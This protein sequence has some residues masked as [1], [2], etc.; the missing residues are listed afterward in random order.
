MRIVIDMQ[1][2]QASNKQ[3]GIGRYSLAFAK[4][5][6]RN[7]GSHEVFILLNGCFAD[8]V[9][10]LREEFEKLL[11]KECIHVWY[12]TGPLNWSG[13]MNSWRRSVAEMTREAAIAS[14]NPSVIVVTSIFE[15]L[16]DD[17]V[18]SVG[19][20]PG[21]PPTVAV[22][23]DLIPALNPDT[24]LANPVVATWY[25]D[26]LRH[27]RNADL[28]FA[29]SESSRQEAI[30]HLGC[31]KIKVVNVSTDAD[32]QFTLRNVSSSHE[33]KLRDK[34]RLK[35]PF[36]MYT[37]GIDHR[38]NI[39]GL[40]RAWALL[41]KTLRCSHQLAIICSIQ[42]E[43]LERIQALAYQHGLLT[44]D[45]VFTGFVPEEDL[46][47]LY[48]ICKLFVFPS[49]HEGFG[50]PALEAMRCGKAVLAA[51]S[52]S[53]PE[54]IGRSD[55][56]F[57]PFNDASISDKI[58]QVLVDDDFREEL[59]QHALVQS[60]FFS[61]DKTGKEA[62]QSLQKL[63]EAINLHCDEKRHSK[64]HKPK[65]AY[66]SPLPPAKS[67]IA[68]Y[69]AALLEELIDFY[70]I[71]LIV[72]QPQ[73][74]LP[75][76]LE[77]LPVRSLDW[78]NVNS[79]KFDRI[80]YNF[81][82][83]PFHS[84]MFAM[85]AKYPGV[86]VLHD[87]YLSGVV[88]HLDI[89]QGYENFWAKAL[90]ESHGYYAVAERFNAVNPDSVTWIYPSNYEVIKE[91]LGVIVHSDYSRDLAAQWYGHH[92]FDNWR[93][94]PLLR[95][96]MNAD[97]E[98]KK[99]ARN[100]LKIDEDQFVVCCFGL[101]GKSKLNHRLLNAW[102]TSHLVNDE[103]CTLIFVGENDA[104]EYGLQL[105][106]IIVSSR[107]KN[108][109]EITGWVD[110]VTFN[111]YLNAADVG[112]Q[113]RALSRGETSAAVLDCMNAGLPTIV[114]A[115]GSMASIADDGV[116]KLPDF[117][118]DDQLA[119]LITKL[120][121]NPE[122]RLALGQRAQQIIRTQHAPSAC[123]DEYRDAIES[124]YRVSSSG[125]PALVKKVGEL[126]CGLPND[127]DLREL[128]QNIDRSVLPSIW[129]RQLLIDISELV[130][131]DAHS[132]I[133]RVVRSIL[134]EWLFNPPEG[135]RVE[136]VY[137][138]E[139]SQEYRYARKFILGVM[140][141]PSEALADEPMTYR[142]GDHF[143]GLDLQHFVVQAQQAYYRRMRDAG[144]NVRFVVYDLLPI[145]WPNCFVEGALS[146]HERWLDV[147]TEQDGAIC[148]SKSVADELTSWIRNK[149]TAKVSHFD[150]GWFHLG[151]DLASSVPTRGLPE[152]A[153]NVLTKLKHKPSFLM[154]GTLEPRKGYAQVLDAFELLWKTGVEVNLVI[155]GKQGWLVDL[156]AERLR[157]H[158]EYN[159]QL[160]WLEGIS[161]EYLEKIYAISSCLIAASYG[162]GFG[163]PLIEA[164]QHKLPIIA[165]DIPV[166][167]E[168][169]SEHAFYFNSSDSFGLAKEINEWLELYKADQHT[170]SGEMPW[171]TWE[172]SA[173]HLEEALFG[174]ESI[175]VYPESK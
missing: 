161:D 78:F 131:R 62:I 15:G 170:K 91:S 72:H 120:Y 92:K 93:V 146:L 77:K 81:G 42:I 44:D 162:E 67:G 112:V 9:L 39:E 142:A 4:S 17:A 96:P 74:S 104:G 52:S 148:I 87:F 141:C 49:W 60:K 43:D 16:N 175:K 86:V 159:S 88:G 125:I 6:I 138:T 76:S 10:P 46:V 151:A 164:A 111:Q 34:Y 118:T 47:N 103:H 174:S 27:V 29:I 123:A 98:A 80:I 158:C 108:R 65:L 140:G 153:I 66:F 1:G 30:T 145:Q 33:T 132:G 110:S 154:V 113:L 107:F 58:K 115:N 155:V 3:R 61:W 105:E 84:H 114:N 24:Y 147:V 28:L 135:F 143:I 134:Q 129:Q 150:I 36:V 50:L 126:E 53:L 95:K 8:T 79:N 163:L 22:L 127:D 149:K 119:E 171:L 169:A 38:K 106:N 48:N 122:E 85:L 137:A 99:V 124:F 55:S 19:G 7:C 56:L 94:I 13:Q 32:P 35:R 63:Y 21:A 71:D 109:I 64:E 26:K 40:V 139:D 41:P 128:A 75:S 152:H 160:F 23:Y 144:V 45:I 37:G 130:K 90:Y 121:R 156:L 69:S 2:A 173:K 166:F 59:E 51:D 157:M 165:R 117:F 57:D 73:I 102:L 136:P 20:L 116:W 14:L 70:E 83:S 167:K 133:Q 101:L 172:Q 97:D 18:T 82:N 25:E 54:V 100:E 11:P 31:D 68:D 168:V 5:L 89:Y 12:A